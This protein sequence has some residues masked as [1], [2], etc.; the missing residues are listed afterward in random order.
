MIEKKELNYSEIV[1]K[2]IIFTIFGRKGG[3]SKTST[4]VL[5][6]D[7]YEKK[8]KRILLLDLD[9]QGNFTQTFFKYKQLKEKDGLYDFIESKKPLAKV[10][11]KYNENI[12]MIPVT[13]D[14]LEEKESV[15]SEVLKARIPEFLDFFSNYDVVIIDCPPSYSAF[16]KLG[17]SMAKYILLPLTPAPYARSGLE[18]ALRRLNTS[19]QTNEIYKGFRAFISSHTKRK[20]LIQEDYEEIYEKVLKPRGYLLEAKMPD[21]VGIVERAASYTNIFDM[22]NNKTIKEIKTL[23]NEINDFVEGNNG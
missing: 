20:V 15:D 18:R 10:V 8:N 5:L 22:Y 6:T 23:F 14:R 19:I 17:L 13:D 11:L 16:T 1:K 3:V 4:S 12:D 2:T 7:Y 9:D 21:Y